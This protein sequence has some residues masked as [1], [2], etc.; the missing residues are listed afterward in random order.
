MICMISLVF[1]SKYRNRWLLLRI[2]IE[3][4]VDSAR[5]FERCCEA[6]NEEF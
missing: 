3:G 6:V 5:H 2:K 4:L 1:C